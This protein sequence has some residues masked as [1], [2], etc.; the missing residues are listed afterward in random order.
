MKQGHLC[1]QEHLLINGW[2]SSQTVRSNYVSGCLKCSVTE[3][4][5]RTPL[6]LIALTC[7]VN[8]TLPSFSLPLSQQQFLGFSPDHPPSAWMVASQPLE[9]P[10]ENSI[11]PAC[12]PE[13]LWIHSREAEYCLSRHCVKQPLTKVRERERVYF[14]SQWEVIGPSRQGSHGGR[15]L[16]Q[17]AHYTH[18]QGSEQRM[19]VLSLLPLFAQSRT[20]AQGTV[21]SFFM[22]NLPIS[23]NLINTAPHS[24]ED[25]LW[26]NPGPVKM[27]IN[28]N[29]PTW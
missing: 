17:W 28:T 22:P 23:V 3:V 9:Q 1:P 13:S 6:F 14:S 27:A 7:C 16:N 29:P 25:G 12:L 20:Q 18:R 26:V 8:L 4:L 11:L 24:P 5:S 19:L 2:L 15:S 10:L 21:L